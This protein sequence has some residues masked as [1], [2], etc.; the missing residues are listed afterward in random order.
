MIALHKEHE[1]ASD[2]KTKVSNLTKLVNSLVAGNS[3]VIKAV[4]SLA[5]E[6]KDFRDTHMKNDSTNV[7]SVQ[8]LD[9]SVLP[10]DT[11]SCVVTSPP[12]NVESSYANVVKN[13]SLS[14]KSNENVVNK[15]DSILMNN[16]AKSTSTV[17]QDIASRKI[18]KVSLCVKSNGVAVDIKKIQDVVSGNGVQVQSHRVSENGDVYLDVPTKE[19]SDQ[20]TSLLKNEINST[21]SIVQLKNKLPSISLLDVTEFISKDTFLEKIKLQNPTVKDLVENKASVL[22]VLYIKKPAE[23]KSFFQV[24]LKVSED[25][26]KTIETRG[27]VLYYNMSALRVVDRFYVKRC[28]NCQNFGHFDNDCPNKVCC[29]FC[30][31][32]HKSSDCPVKDTEGSYRCVNCERDKHDHTL[33]S[34]FSNKCESFRLYQEK[35]KKGIPYYRNSKNL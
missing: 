22:E 33:H 21:Q 5:T 17:T 19:V 26:R 18:T 6:F 29:G 1:T 14:V 16:L 24:V 31:Q 11:I 27:N 3:V 4:N 8:V 35:I 7:P 34:T 2:L 10:E 12:S 20:L 30:A 25:V 13:D 9:P 28:N 32:E 23:G 15:N